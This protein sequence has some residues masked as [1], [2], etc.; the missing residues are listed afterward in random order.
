MLL[1]LW[2]CTYAAPEP[3]VHVENQVRRTGT[4]SIAVAVSAAVI[5]RPTGLTAFPDGGSPKLDNQQGIFYLCVASPTSL[6]SWRRIRSL[7]RPDSLHTNFAPWVRTWDGPESV[8][9]SFSGYVGAES[10]VEAFRRVWFRL[11]LTG[12]VTPIAV[13]AQAAEYAVSL[14]P[15]CEAAIVADAK[16]LL[17][18]R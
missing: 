7:P 18:E 9:A 13:K 5:R 16:G 1:L 15:A 6:S 12:E 17:A 14:P 10:S 3:L 2:S 4:D 11:R 8:I